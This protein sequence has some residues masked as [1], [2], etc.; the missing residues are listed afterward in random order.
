MR[1]AMG[2][3]LSTPFASPISMQTGS[4]HNVN[5]FC[6]PSLPQTRRVLHLFDV[7]L[8]CIHFNLEL[9]LSIIMTPWTG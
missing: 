8:T 6:R 1:I 5:A 2:Y 9:Q 7:V 4:L 3:R